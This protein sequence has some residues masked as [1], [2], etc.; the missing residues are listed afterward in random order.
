MDG[1]IIA[2]ID[3]LGAFQQHIRQHQNHQR[4]TLL[5]GGLAH[6]LQ[7]F[8]LA[9]QQLLA[10]HTGDLGH[11]QIDTGTVEFLKVG[12][13]HLLCGL[14]AYGGG[15]DGLAQL[16][17]RNI[18]NTGHTLGGADIPGGAGG[19]FE[20]NGIGQNGGGHHTC[21]GGRGHQATVLEHTGDDGIG[22][23]NRL[24]ADI[25]GI[26]GLD[27]RQAVMV[28][29]LQ[30]LCLFQTG[31]GL[32]GF[33]MVHQNH[34]LSAGAQQVIP[35]EDA[36]HMLV[37][38]QNG[39]AGEAVL[40]HDIPHIIHPVLQVEADQLPVVADTADGGGLEDQSGS[41]VGI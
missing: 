34:P 41:P 32:G 22:G 23:A 18:G 26:G 14:A 4:Q 24:I 20:H 9:A 21:H 16:L 13:E 10:V 6:Q 19:R 37:F 11:R 27:I 40:Q 28:D 2:Q 8:F 1:L 25:N 29:D 39:V 35:A 33:V 36:N 38:I 5:P 12:E 15:E 30:N 3:D 7:E 17:Q 31:H